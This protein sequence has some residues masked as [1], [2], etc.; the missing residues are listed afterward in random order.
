MSYTGVP[1]CDC[2]KCDIHTV[3]NQGCK[4]PHLN[5][6]IPAIAPQACCTLLPCQMVSV[7]PQ[8][9]LR[10][11]LG[12]L[13]CQIREVFSCLYKAD[14]SDLTGYA[15]DYYDGSAELK[16]N[17]KKASDKVAFFQGYVFEQGLWISDEDLVRLKDVALALDIFD[18]AKLIDCARLLFDNIIDERTIQT[19]DTMT[20][21]S[22]CRCVS[23]PKF[24]FL[25]DEEFRCVRFSESIFSALYHRVRMNITKTRELEGCVLFVTLQ[26]AI[27]KGLSVKPPPS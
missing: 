4:K 3:C 1:D 12:K 19:R 22:Y 24:V 27:Q 17:L 14:P 16:E 11:S 8:Y 6:T 25:I 10:Y 9:V 26:T 7:R 15:P 23:M 13:L 21:P 18:A 20:F 5:H 2:G